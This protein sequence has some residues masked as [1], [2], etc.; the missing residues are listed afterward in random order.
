MKNIRFLRTGTKRHK[1]LGKA[2]KNKQI[3]RRPKGR[4]NKI[5][6][7]EKSKQRKVQIGFRSKP[8]ERGK[9]K[10][11]PMLLVRNIKEAENVKT[12]DYV[13]IGKMG[14]KKKIEIEKVLEDKKAVILNK[15]KENELKK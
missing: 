4:H 2:N 10:G 15:R 12:G 6:Q 11:K 8:E 5:R 7:N 1:R 14:K 3:W 9:I 13:I